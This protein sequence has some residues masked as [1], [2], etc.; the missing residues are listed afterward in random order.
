MS[1]RFGLNY[2]MSQGSF[3]TDVPL[4]ENAFQFSRALR[5]AA[6]GNYDPEG[7]VGESAPSRDANLQLPTGFGLK[8]IMQSRADP[9]EQ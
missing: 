6:R 1:W 7:C 2:L 9:R 8:E 5:G 4:R 3:S